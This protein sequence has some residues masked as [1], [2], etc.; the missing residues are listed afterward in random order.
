MKKSAGV[1]G[2]VVILGGAYLGATW[3]VGKQAQAELE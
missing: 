2:A 1:I 3:Y